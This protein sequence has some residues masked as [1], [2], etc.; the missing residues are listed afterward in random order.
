[1]SLR[2]VL[3][4]LGV[5]LGA[6]LCLAEPLA[7]QV[8]EDW[9]GQWVFENGRCVQV[10]GSMG[11]VS[12]GTLEGAVGLRQIETELKIEALADDE[13]RAEG[14]A[15]RNVYRHPAETLIWF[16]IDPDMTVVEIWP[17]R[18][19][20]Y[21]EILAPL[22]NESGT[23]YAAGYVTGT[24]NEYANSSNTQFRAKLDAN[25]ELYG[26]AIVSEL[27][28]DAY[29][30]APPCSADMVLTFRNVHNWMTRLY[31]QDVF[32]AMYRALEPGG[33][34]GVVEHRANPYAEH[35]LDG[36]SGYVTEAA[37]IAFAEAAGF[38]RLGRSEVNAN[39]RDTKDHPRG[40]WTLPP[41]LRLGE[42]DSEKYL[43]I[44][45]SDR[46]TLKFTRPFPVE[47]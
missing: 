38:E 12:S 13:H 22:L 24:D 15:G 10:G 31:A 37:V 30:I 6:L 20:W 18:H 39:P 28:E 43:A 40:V 44:G 25:P 26:N 3:L 34:L 41:S 29:D 27:G 8:D 4:K 9:R 14:H 32:D 7:A 19:G 42:E 35:D 16:G 46:M 33:I 23:Y 11:P 1:M 21:T 36:R 47:S 45:E 17:G 5:A 2:S